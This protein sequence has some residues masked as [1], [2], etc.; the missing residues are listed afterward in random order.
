MAPIVAIGSGQ[1]R[2]LR[3]CSVAAAA[4]VVAVA[5]C[6]APGS[7]LESAPAVSVA[8]IDAAL[9]DPVWSYHD[10]ELLGLTDDHRLAAI[11]YAGPGTAHTRLSAPM[12]SGRNLQISQKDDRHVFV[13]QPERGKV[14]VVDIATLRP[15]AEIDAGPAPSYLA[16]DAGMR[17][18]LALAADG[19]SVTPVD[20]YGFRK[21]PT[22]TYA[23]EPADTIDGSNRGRQIEYHLYG[24]SGIRYYKGPTSPPEERGSL[25]MAVAV[26]AGDGT[27]VTRSYVAGRDDK[28]LYAVDS[29]RGGDGLE[30]LARTELSSP[31]RYL[32]TD[33]TRIYAA[34]DRDVTVLETASF[35][36]FP[37]GTIRVIRT[38][39]YRAGLPSGPVASAPLSG[40][41]IGPKRVYLTLRGQPHVIS[42]AKPRL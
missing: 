24:A 7:S 21:L 42:V 5:G 37:N 35:T 13:P 39:D 30:V 1:R 36:G 17:V 25:P 16:E 6:S 28:V 32:G 27:Q 22:A 10:H 14:A 8:T 34:T 23:G 18:L 19:S 11:G 41:A 31:I 9:H 33:D 29:R 26:W 15:V 2:R 40:M 4:A 3:R 20:Q 38:L 12:G